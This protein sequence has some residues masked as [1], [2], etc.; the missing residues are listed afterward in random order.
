MTSDHITQPVNMVDDPCA[1]PDS[2]R[3]TKIP[4]IFPKIGRL[5]A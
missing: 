3:L 1:H 5:A 4:P 2:V